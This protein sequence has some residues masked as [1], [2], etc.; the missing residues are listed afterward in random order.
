MQW[1]KSCASMSRWCSSSRMLPKLLLL[2][3]LI[4]HYYHYCQCHGKSQE[5]VMMPQVTVAE[6]LRFYAAVVLPPCMPQADRSARIQSALAV[7]GLQQAQN[8]LVRQ[9]GR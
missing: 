9:Q 2:L 6:V 1:Q 8:T 3:L 4:A 7:M 5:D